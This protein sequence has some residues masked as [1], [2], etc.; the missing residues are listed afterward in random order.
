MAA[1]HGGDLAAQFNL[2]Q[3]HRLGLSVARSCNTA[4]VLYKRVWAGDWI[5]SLT[6]SA[7]VA[8]RGKYLSLLHDAHTL[9]QNGN[10]ANALFLYE[11]AAE[12][13]FE[14]AQSNAAWL[15]DHHADELM[16]EEETKTKAFDYYRSAQQKSK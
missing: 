1:A 12:M 13:G 6:G 8:E 9:Y 5:V 11:K 4:V 10:T 2:A 7:Q 3:M 14:L 16:T 15:Y